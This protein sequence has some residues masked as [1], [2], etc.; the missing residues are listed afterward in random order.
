MFGR[1]NESGEANEWKKEENKNEWNGMKCS[2]SMS[3]IY[4][5]LLI[6]TVKTKTVY[7]FIVHRKMKS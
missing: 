7:I 3:C 2:L 1:G 5:L 6:Q 4:T